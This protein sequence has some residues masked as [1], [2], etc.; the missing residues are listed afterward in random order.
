VPNQPSRT[1]ALA[2]EETTKSK[3]AIKGPHFSP[4]MNGGA[5]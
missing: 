2:T 5:G 1:G 4:N 3:G